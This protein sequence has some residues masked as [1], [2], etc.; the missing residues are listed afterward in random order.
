MDTVECKEMIVSTLKRRG[1]G[2]ENNPI[3]VITEVFEKNGTKIAENDP[4]PD[5]FSAEEMV[6]FCQWCIKNNF[7]VQNVHVND[8]RTW[9]NNIGFIK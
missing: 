1:D 3:R 5:K 6:G 4:V 2:N 9:R 7:Q 8:I